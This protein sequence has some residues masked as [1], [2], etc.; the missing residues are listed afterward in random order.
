MKKKNS[1]FT[2]VELVVVITIIGILVAAIGVSVS[3]A[4]SSKARK[5]A[6]EI[7]SFISIARTKCLSKAG[8]PY[9]IIKSDGSDIVGQ[10]Y[11]NDTL[12]DTTELGRGVE[13]SYDLGGDP[14]QLDT[15][16]LR[17]SFERSTGMPRLY[18]ADNSWSE[19]YEDI[20]IT[21]TGGGR[22]FTVTIY[23]LT[24]SHFVE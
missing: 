13:V 23:A 17:L 11:E 19:A 2:L 18:G 20:S 8:G 7:D 3:A 1:G 14:S 6:E 16:G 4:S 22:S 9:I 24:G 12:V 21:V 10:Y 5:C 15:A